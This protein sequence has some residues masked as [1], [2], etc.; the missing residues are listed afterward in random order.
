MAEKIVWRCPS[1]IAFVKYWGKKG[2][3]IPCNASI[4]MTLQNAF[5]E[6]A[7]TL[8][9]KM[10]EGIEIDYFFEG[11]KNEAFQKRI[12]GYLE[13]NK[14]WFPVLEQYSIHIDS[15]NSFPHSTGIASSASA[16]GAL[17]LAL[18]S[19]SNYNGDDFLQRASYLSR[20]GSGSACR[21]M[22]SGYA[23]WGKLDEI[24]GSSDDFAVALTDIHPDFLDMR[25][26]ILIVDDQPK[27]VSSSVGHG[28]MKGHAYAETRFKDANRH[29]LELKNILATGDFENFV[30]LIEREALALHAMM[31]TS[32]D[33]Y[34]LM[35]PN[36]VAIIDA[37]MNFRKETGVPVAFTL[38]AGPNVHVIYPG[39]FEQQ[40]SLFLESD[41]RNGL[42]GVINDKTGTG[43]KKTV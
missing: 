4:S 34:L 3:Q 10:N 38:D 31:M 33:Y 29:C 42:K 9:E 14:V 19:A 23:L 24:P 27:P 17:T 5:T 37:I 41:L 43:P 2:N 36:T 18:L 13:K 32:Q 22:Y 11:Q 40:V 8:G 15:S 1:N 39:K 20:L 26:T 30:S 12:L 7:L 25:D 16:F 21:S 35:K 6:T 28:L